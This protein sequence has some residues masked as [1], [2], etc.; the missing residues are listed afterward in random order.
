MPA[1][2]ARRVQRSDRGSIRLSAV[3][4]GGAVVLGLAGCEAVAQAISVPT[5]AEYAQ[6]SPDT[7]LGS[8][9]TSDQEAAITKILVA[10]GREDSETNRL[11]AATQIVAYCNIYA[12]QAGSNADSPIDGIPGLQD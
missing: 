3:V 8:S 7:G 10:N 5:C 11:I 9:L 4:A 6:M 1:P 2:R 12:G